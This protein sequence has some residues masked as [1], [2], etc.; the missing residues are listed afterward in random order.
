MAVACLADLRINAAGVV[1][2][3]HGVVCL[4]R[5]TNILPISTIANTYPQ[6]K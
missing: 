5:F 3:V 2:F 1:Q 4:N 6:F